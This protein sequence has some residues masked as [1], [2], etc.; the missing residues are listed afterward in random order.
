M[1]IENTD[2]VARKN[3]LAMSSLE[4]EEDKDFYYSF[5]EAM[6]QHRNY[7][8]LTEIFVRGFIANENVKQDLINK[9]CLCNEMINDLINELLIEDGEFR[10]AKYPISDIQFKQIFNASLNYSETSYNMMS[11]FYDR[12]TSEERKNVIDSS[13]NYFRSFQDYVNF[14]YK[15]LNETELQDVY[16]YMLNNLSSLNENTSKFAT[17]DYIQKTHREL[18]SC[19][20]DDLK[21]KNLIL[22]FRLDLIKKLLEIEPKNKSICEFLLNVFLPKLH[23]NLLPLELEYIYQTYEHNLFLQYKG[24]YNPY[25]ILTDYFHTVMDEKWYVTLTNKLLKGRYEQDINY[26]LRKYDKYP[27]PLKD[28]LYSK[29]L[30]NKL[31]SKIV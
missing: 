20:D 13:K 31:I 25:R 11:K 29:L 8:N 9:I 5:I 3:F 28:K 17:Y 6:F 4:T 12:F 27:E 2:Y 24:T 18:K 7:N 23:I 10:I 19:E 22:K 16:D 14:G 26:F 1:I 15:F 30:M 21:N